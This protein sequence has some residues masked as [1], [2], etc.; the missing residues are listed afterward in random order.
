MIDQNVKNLVMRIVSMAVSFI[1]TMIITYIVVDYIGNE[2]YGFYQMSNDIINYA[3]VITVALNSMSSRFITISYIQEDFDDASKYYNSVLFGNIVLAV[4]LAIPSSVFILMLDKLIDVPDVYLH[5]VKI[6]FVLMF[7]NF[8]VTICSSVL[9][10][11]TFVKNRIDLDS[12]RTIERELIRVI[13]VYIICKFLSPHI[14]CVGVSILASTIFACIRNYCYT[15]KLVPEIKLFKKEFF[16]IGRIK[17]LVQSGL[18]NSLTQLG[19]I[20][21]NGLDLIIANQMIGSMAMGTLSVAKTLPKYLL[22]AM[23]AVASVFTPKIMIAYAEGN[24]EKLVSIIY[25]SIKVCALISI[26]I[27]VIIIVLSRRLYI[28]WISGQDSYTLSLLTIVSMFGYVVLMPLQVLW[29][30]FTA[31]NRVK[32]SSLYLL[33]ES[34]LAILAVFW[35]LKIT[36]NALI[37]M[38]IIAGV[39]SVFELIRGLTFLPAV[40]AGLLDIK[41]RTFYKPL[42]RSLIAF[43]FSVFV[44]LMVNKL[45]IHSSWSGF[46]LLCFIDILL[47]LIVCVFVLFDR[48]EIHFV[49]RMFKIKRGEK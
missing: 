1:S 49:L 40:S 4:A 32:V 29:A 19:Q 41:L 31:T 45:P 9:S 38:V 5:D 36:D 30:V 10:T 23:T 43:G 14:W 21:R 26:C 34:I 8:F 13:I 25:T 16:D 3:T 44:S 33:A 27:E 18:W 37:K 22:A 47:T 48:N 6:L 28:L 42:F 39:S 15:L 12:Y 11:A 24:K 35:L 7:I 46:A 20:L 2:L 17:E